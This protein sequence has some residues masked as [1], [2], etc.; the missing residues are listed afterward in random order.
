MAEIE[1]LQD[2]NCILCSEDPGIGIESIPYTMAHKVAGDRCASQ[3][4]MRWPQWE[5]MPPRYKLDPIHK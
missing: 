1:V 3:V 4:H 2:L 5:L